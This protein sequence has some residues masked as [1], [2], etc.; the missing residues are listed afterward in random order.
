MRTALAV[1]LLLLGGC[2]SAPK[3][4][5]REVDMILVPKLTPEQ[6]ED[7]EIAICVDADVMRLWNCPTKT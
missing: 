6:M 2:A 7:A 3:T 5:P 4:V 1:A